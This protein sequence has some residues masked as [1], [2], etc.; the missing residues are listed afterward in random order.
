MFLTLH[1]MHHN[2]SHKMFMRACWQPSS[3]G[4]LLLDTKFGA[5]GLGKNMPIAVKQTHIK[6]KQR[7][8][9]RKVI[10]Q[11][12]EIFPRFQRRF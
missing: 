1:Q 9:E 11:A 7:R 5:C 3:G 4:A 8:K 10:Q 12:Q 6:E 2:I